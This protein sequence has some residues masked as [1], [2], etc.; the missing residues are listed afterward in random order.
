M[1]PQKTLIWS[2]PRTPFAEKEVIGGS[3]FLRTVYLLTVF[4]T[5]LHKQ[6]SLF[7][8]L[9]VFPNLTLFDYIVHF[10]S[11]QSE[12]TLTHSTVFFV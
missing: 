4:G 11:L 3:R 9:C 7:I 2:V 10:V 5:L 6:Y 12:Q 8:C 1:V